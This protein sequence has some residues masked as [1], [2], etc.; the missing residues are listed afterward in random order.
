MTLVSRK[1]QKSGSTSNEARGARQ[2]TSVVLKLGAPNQC[3][4]VP[5]GRRGSCRAG[6]I[7]GV[8][9][10]SVQRELRPPS[11]AVNTSG[12][13]VCSCA[14]DFALSLFF[15]RGRTRKNAENR[16]GT[17]VFRFQCSVF[18][19]RKARPRW[20]D[21]PAEP[22]ESVACR[23]V[24]FSGNFALRVSQSTPLAMQSAVAHRISR[25]SK[26]LHLLKRYCSLLEQGFIDTLLPVS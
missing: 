12:N 19:H 2:P 4:V 18:S 5:L 1:R 8:P 9:G 22:G 16:M 26:S 15:G 25:S 7:S 14:Q 11:I 10:S 23:G 17:S 20:A 21:A 13:A 24:R 3:S 6:G